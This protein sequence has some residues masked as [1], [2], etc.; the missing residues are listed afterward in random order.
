MLWKINANKEGNDA[1]QLL[2]SGQSTATTWVMITI[3]K[4]KSVR[5]YFRNP[6]ATWTNENIH[7]SAQKTENPSIAVY[8]NELKIENP[9]NANAEGT[10]ELVK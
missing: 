9:S 3:T 7:Y 6:D 10:F 8:T 1:V 5:V 2:W 4:G